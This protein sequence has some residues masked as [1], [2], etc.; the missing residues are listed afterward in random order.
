MTVSEGKYI[1]TLK[2]DA[3]NDLVDKVKSQVSAL[4]GKVV[5]EF[6]LIKGFVAHVPHAGVD[7]LKSHDG[8]VNVEQD[9]EVKI[10]DSK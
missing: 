3:P 10:Q 4:G 1:V 5:D 7:K 2:E 8:V 9:Q 6:S